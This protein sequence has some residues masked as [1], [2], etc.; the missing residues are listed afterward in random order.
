MRHHNHCGTSIYRDRARF[1]GS[2]HANCN[3]SLT[4]KRFLTVGFHGLTN[5]DSKYIISGAAKLGITNI[6]VIAKTLEKYLSITIDNKLRFICTLSHKPAA[7]DSLVADLKLE[8]C[9]KF[10]ITRQVFSKLNAIE[11]SDMI[12]KLPFCYEYCTHE[13]LNAKNAS[14]PPIEV[15]YSSLKNENV[16]IDGYNRGQRVYKMFGCTTLME[17]LKIYNLLD[18]SLLADVFEMHR[19]Q[20]KKLLKVDPLN[21][22]S[23]SS[24]A[25]K[26]GMAKSKQKLEYVKSMDL[27]L[28]VKESYH[29]GV[30]NVSWRHLK[31]NIPGKKGYR[32]DKP[33]EFIFQ[34]DAISLYPYCMRS[35]LC[36]GNYEK[37]TDEEISNFDPMTVD[38]DG[39]VG[40]ILK[41]DIEIPPEKH[42][43]F[44]DLPLLPERVKI[45]KSQASEYQKEFFENEA[46]PSNFN[47]EQYL[48]TLY[49]K[50][51]YVLFIP[52]LQQAIRLG[53]KL[54]KIHVAYR[55]E[56]VAFYKDVVD[57]YMT[58][59]RNAKSEVEK[60]AAKDAINSSY[61]TF[62]IDQQKFK[63]I[64]LVT[65]QARALN[66]VRQHNFGSFKII[67]EMLSIVE[68]KK[69]SACM[70]N[71]LIVAS[72]ILD[73]SK[74][75]LYECIYSLKDHF[76]GRIRNAYIDTDSSLF[77]IVTDDPY[78]ELS[79]IMVKGEPL[80]D[81]SYLTPASPYYEKYYSVV[82]QG[83]PGK[84]RSET[85]DT[86]ILEYYG[87]K[88]KVYVCKLDG[89]K[90]DK[91]R[92]KSLPR[93]SM[94][95]V[96]IKTYRR[97][98]YRKRVK[99]V[100][101]R[102]LRSLNLQM[103]SILVHRIG[104]TPVCD[105]RFLLGK[106]GIASYP[107]GHKNIVNNTHDTV[108]EEGSSCEMSV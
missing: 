13:N 2:A 100:K 30:C 101:V 102:M 7:L 5:F 99:R 105:S 108:Y 36:V 9:D 53:L 28:L 74:A 95:K 78:G 31:A 104:F 59:R 85:L 96:N 41:V 55:Y 58:L 98:I 76:Q 91:K 10:K 43:Y 51:G 3:L 82:N 11:L 103:C 27:F 32:P 50:K 26:A 80:F 16:S 39:P 57:S 46:I 90:P 92:A 77:S 87:V 4:S 24:M 93:S 40:Y 8:G 66:L 20:C 60:K 65:D 68:M 52:M 35:P 106:Y 70:S 97:T 107:F 64:H 12:G 14:L 72:A 71:N 54:T 44:R 6:S 86:L 63:N 37:L 1:I 69:K 56:Q 49:D 75:Y 48:T 18:C 29:G 61:G 17:Y 83:V 89:Q 67:N 88:K 42:D 73:R 25:F 33:T 94:K 19:Q 21:F 45:D 15:F 47:N 84:W 23:L 79:Q 34:F 81:F 62:G 38:Q 22:V